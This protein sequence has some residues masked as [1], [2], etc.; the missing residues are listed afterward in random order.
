M[1]A[2]AQQYEVLHVDAGE[3]LTERQ[4]HAINISGTLAA[5]A[6]AAMGILVNK[7][8]ADRDDAAVALE[9]RIPFRAGAAVSRGDRL[10][11]STSGWLTTAD[12]GDQVVGL[13]EF[14]VASGGIGT[15]RFDFRVPGYLAS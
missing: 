3:D 7:P 4:F 11:V 8:T 1:S 2:N 14:G 13:C 5:N 15:G 12:S 9:G 6:E 10:T